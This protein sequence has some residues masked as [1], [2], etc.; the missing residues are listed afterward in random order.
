M[1]TQ[2]AVC[3]RW[4]P[5]SCLCFSVFHSKSCG[6]VSRAFL[7]RHVTTDQEMPDDHVTKNGLI[8][9]HVYC[10]NATS[11]HSRLVS[12]GC[13]DSRDDGSTMF[14]CQDEND[15][16]CPSAVT[17]QSCTKCLCSNARGTSKAFA[18][19]AMT[20]AMCA[21]SIGLMC[22]VFPKDFSA[23]DQRLCPAVELKD[24]IVSSCVSALSALTLRQEFVRIKLQ[25]GSGTSSDFV[26]MDVARDS[27]RRTFMV[28]RLARHT[29]AVPEI[30]ESSR[31]D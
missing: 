28:H 20:K 19:C 30:S 4:R 13:Q 5:E 25:R 12:T 24:V 1:L 22:G 8:T 2:I 23:V 29:C 31:F 21:R 26:N 9:C 11:F 6:A 15:R 27:I 10:W 17:V 3:R 18:E 7:S 16:G 14:I